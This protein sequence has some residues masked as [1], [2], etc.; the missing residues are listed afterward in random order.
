MPNAKEYLKRVSLFSLM[1][2]D[3]LERIARLA[4][5]HTYGEGEVIIREGDQDTQLFVIISGEVDI[6]KDLG[7]KTEW[8]VRV[9]GPY[10]YFGEMAII[11]ELTRSASVVARGSVDVLSLSQLQLRNEISRYPQMAFELLQML[12]RRIRAI[13]KN[14]V[15]TLGTFLPICSNC[16][17]IRSETGAWANIDEYIMDHSETEFTHSICPACA[18]KLY[19]EFM[20]RT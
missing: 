13:E 15:N 5:F 4:V 11:D 6:V 2:T 8:K 16:K 9:L 17:K 3:D 7:K 20:E 19:P 14:M 1:K 18:E 10:S 12:S